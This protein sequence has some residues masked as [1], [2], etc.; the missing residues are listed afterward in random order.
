MSSSNAAPV[1]DGAPELVKNIARMVSEWEM[2][3]ELPTEFAQRV[4]DLVSF[5][6]VPNLVGQR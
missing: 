4:V 3:D 6:I 5:Q 2:S 1:G